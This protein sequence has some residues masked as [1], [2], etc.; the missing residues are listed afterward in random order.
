MVVAYSKVSWKKK[1]L[2]AN[3]VFTRVFSFQGLNITWPK[4]DSPLDGE[5][6]YNNSQDTTLVNAKA[7]MFRFI[8]LSLT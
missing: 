4:Q 5:G 8:P 7:S 1:T 3:C 2:E 6:N